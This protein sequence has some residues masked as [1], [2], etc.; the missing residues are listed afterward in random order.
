[1]PITTITAVTPGWPEL[2]RL[3]GVAYP[4]GQSLNWNHIPGGNIA[5]AYFRTQ[6]PPELEFDTDRPGFPA[7]GYLWPTCPCRSNL[8]RPYLSHMR[9]CRLA[10]A[11][12]YLL[13]LKAGFGLWSD[14]IRHQ[15]NYDSCPEWVFACSK[16][17]RDSGL[18]GW[19]TNASLDSAIASRSSEVKVSPE[20]CVLG[21]LLEE[22]SVGRVAIVVFAQQQ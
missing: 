10:F 11:F 3:N 1:M 9:T 2:R 12:P 4:H 16:E 8:C 17:P 20:S 7:Q 21:F 6:L 14:F 5:T 22:L 19:R 13:N 18:R 15:N